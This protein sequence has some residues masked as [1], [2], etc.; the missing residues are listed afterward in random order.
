MK[1]I[2]EKEAFDINTYIT[3]GGYNALKKAF[4]KKPQ[5]I[6][7]E[8][9]K[10][11]LRG[12]GG[13]GFPTGLKWSFIPKAEM[14]KYVI[15][16]A[17]EGEPGTFKDREIIHR[18]PH[19][20]IEGMIIAGYAI[21]ANKG[22]IYIRG[23]FAREARILEKTIYEAVHF[24]F[25]GKNILNSGFDFTIDIVRGAGAYICGEETALLESIEGKQGKPR[26]KPPFPAAKGLF[27]C[28]TLI[29][30]VETLAAV[31]YIILMGGDKYSKIGTEKSS[32]TKLFSVSGPVKK[33]GVYEIELGMPFK[34][35]FWEFLGGMKEAEELKAVIVG[36][37]S[38]PVITAEEAMNVNLDYESLS[39]AGTMLGSGGMIIIPKSQCMVDLLYVLV[40]FYHHES[41]GQCTPCREG[42][43]WI[44][45]IIKRIR[46]FNSDFKDI[47]LALDVA[48]SIVG[49][50]ICPLA[51]ALAMPLISF[52]TKFKDEFENHV[53]GS[54]KICQR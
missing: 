6:I 15:C 14:N 13:A 29:N 49:R 27:G 25:L 31:P 42:S 39:S 1:I 52:I 30:N 2:L 18:N 36:G 26:I 12:R 8:I 53:K 7:E 35:F 47:D 44:E 19:S 51:D 22:Y 32:G 11:G 24:G 37:S 9:K 28:P 45:K 20:I 46:Y 38:V 34:K 21:G 4:T 10:S 23:E 5:D 50:T 16:N 3:N 33:P 40:R 41:C 17:D 43:G 48:N 54:C